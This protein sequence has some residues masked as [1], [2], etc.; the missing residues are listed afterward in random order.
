MKIKN[1]QKKQNNFCYSHVLI[2]KNKQT[3]KRTKSDI[4]NLWYMSSA[5]FHLSKSSCSLGTEITL[6]FP[7]GI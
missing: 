5:P 3:K 4:L 7:M 6:L 2:Y 1:K